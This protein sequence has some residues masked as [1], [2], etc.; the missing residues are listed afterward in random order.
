MK[1]GRKLA[2][3]L[4]DLSRSFPA[5]CSTPVVSEDIWQRLQCFV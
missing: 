5:H 4:R 3:F 1:Q 2:E